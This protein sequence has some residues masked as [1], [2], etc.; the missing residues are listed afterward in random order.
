MDNKKKKLFVRIMAGVL[1]ALMVF[2]M[3]IS[4]IM[5]LFA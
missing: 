2:P 3:G 5:A 4:L 1:V